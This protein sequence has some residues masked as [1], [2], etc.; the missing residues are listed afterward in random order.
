MSRRPSRLEA[1]LRVRRIQEEHR[2]ADHSRALAAEAAAAQ[3][4]EAALRGYEAGAGQAGTVPVAA[5]VAERALAAARADALGAAEVRHAL[6][7]GD[8]ERARAL[9][10]EASTRTSALER[11][12]ERAERQRARDQ[13]A[14]D[15]RAAEES[16]AAGREVDR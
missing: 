5:F 4:C 10:T 7:V 2:Q 14:A 1:V 16:A 15:Q 8:R 13:L 3:D 12:V 9:L 11:L 6:A